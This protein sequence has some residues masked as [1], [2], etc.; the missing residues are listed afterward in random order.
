MTMR[1]EFLFVL[2]LALIFLGD[3]LTFHGTARIFYGA[4]QIFVG[5][6][7][8]FLTVHRFYKL[9]RELGCSK[10][11]IVSVIVGCGSFFVVLF[12]VILV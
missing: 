7:L 2:A 6:V 8:I 10:T 9:L 1:L 12:Y 4:A 3:V 5:I 11:V